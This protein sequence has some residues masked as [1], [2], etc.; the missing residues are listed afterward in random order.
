MN[1]LPSHQLP[2]NSPHSEVKSKHALA[3]RMVAI[4]H[5]EYI[6][7]KWKSTYWEIQHARACKREDAL[8]EEIKKNEALIR[9]LKQRLYGKKSE[10]GGSKPDANPNDS[11]KKKQSGLED[12][13]KEAL[14]MGALST[15]ISPSL[16]RLSKSRKPPVGHVV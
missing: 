7:L 1:S 10:K 14:D 9:D 11:L 12:S 16:W 4:T 15:P 8:K 6:A 13:K 3:A 2:V 5:Q